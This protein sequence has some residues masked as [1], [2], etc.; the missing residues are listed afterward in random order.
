MRGPQTICRLQKP[1]ETRTGTGG[2]DDTW[3]DLVQFAGVL[4]E[5]TATEADLFNRETTVST[6]KLMVMAYRIGKDNIAQV[7]EPNII[8]VINTENLMEPQEFDIAGVIPVKR[9]RGQVI[10]FKIMLREVV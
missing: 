5:L 1:T 7:K 8:S 4:T 10:M 2:G 9:G 3:E 6:H